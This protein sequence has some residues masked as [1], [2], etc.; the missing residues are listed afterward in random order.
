MADLNLQ[1]LFVRVPSSVTSFNGATVSTANPSKIYFDEGKNLIWA[2]GKSYGLS[3]DDATNLSNLISWVGAT[4]Q[5]G[6]RKAVADNTTA[7]SVLNGD[8]TTEGSVKKAV[9][10]VLTTYVNADSDGVINKLNEIITWFNNVKD[11][12]TAAATL[13]SDVAANKSAIG[14][15]A[16]DT[17]AATG[18]YKY[19]DDAVA[20]SESALNAL[21]VADNVSD[22]VA[23]ITVKVDEIDGK[24]QK[25]V[26]TVTAAT[27]DDNLTTPTVTDSVLSGAAI[28]HIKAYVDAK[29]A[30]CEAK[31][32][33]S[34]EITAAAVTGDDVYGLEAGTVA[35]QITGLATAI[36]TIQAGSIAIAESGKDDTDNGVKV[37]VKTKDGSVSAVDVAVTPG[38]VTVA[39]DGALT[40]TAGVVDAAALATTL[41][42]I[43]ASAY[44][45]TYAG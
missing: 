35:S 37:E 38:S 41:S 22:A 19:V 6:L 14:T 11:T 18:L 21:D 45:E 12:D 42:S 44:W 7:I 25:P 4:D 31:H 36:K 3:S 1:K 32:D 33:S 20:A 27:T 10:D 43:S 16:T 8:A 13:I 34:D 15:K 5:E 17:A 24:V 23:G 9:N 40:E 29:D 30:E 28:A 39:S 26:V 2:Q